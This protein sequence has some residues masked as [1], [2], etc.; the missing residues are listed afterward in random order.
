MGKLQV[1]R[2]L[3]SALPTLDSGELGF[4]TDTKRLFVGGIDG[5]NVEFTP[6]AETVDFNIH[7]A[8]SVFGGDT[9]A[10]GKTGRELAGG[11]TTST[12][13]NQLVDSAASFTSAMVGE[14]VHNDTDDTWAKVTSFVSATTLGISVDIMTSGEDY[15][16]VSALDNLTDGFNAVDSSFRAN[17]S[18]LMTPETFDGTTLTIVGKTAGAAKTLTFKGSTSGTTTISAEVDINQKIFFTNIVFT[19][20][21]FE[22]FG[23]DVDWTTCVTS[24][25][26]GFI[27][28]KSISI[29]N[30]F[31]SSSVVVF[32]SDP[33]LFTNIASTVTVGYTIYTATS[34]LGGSDTIN[35]GLLITQGTATSTSANKLVDSTANFNS[36]Q[37]LNKTVYN[38]TDNTWAEITAIDSTTQ[39]SLDQDIMVSGES[40]ELAAARST[41]QG[42]IDVIPGSV[43]C[44]TLQRISNGTFSEEVTYQGKGFSG[45]FN[46]TSRGTLNLE[47]TVSSATIAQNGSATQG[48]VTKA[49]AFTSDVYAGFLAYFV[50]DDDWRII[51]THT[52]DVLTLIANAPSNTT[53]DVK[54]YSW[55]TILNSGGAIDVNIKDG[56][57]GIF[58][59][60][61]EFTNRVAPSG[62]SKVDVVRSHLQ[63]RLQI[64][65]GS[66]GN[67]DRC[68]SDAPIAINSITGGSG[69]GGYSK[70]INSGGAFGV[71]ADPGSSYIL[72]FGTVIDGYVKGSNAISTSI[73]LD[74]GSIGY[75]RIRNCTTGLLGTSNGVHVAGNAA[76]SNLQ[77]SGNTTDASPAINSTDF[78]HTGA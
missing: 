49:A 7:L 14:T 57:L 77:F 23:A 19:S 36:A 24:G 60:D 18:I 31:R 52:N 15:H 32:K 10:N 56:Q 8:S 67:M 62:L 44:N 69:Q 61:L 9:E 50:T 4:A 68:W 46:I 75:M 78:S 33:G 34:A 28:T 12:S 58:L 1:R 72:A 25:D 59:D 43:N 35:D 11:T 16:V 73:R 48:T 76:L 71:R 40:Y 30:I 21:I 41:W 47:E 39:V 55:N 37:H 54:I 13:A 2:G 45:A 5:L 51:D 3:R 70:L 42:G 26:D 38:S 64:V 29:A 66:I 63:D 22:N 27:I 20:R 65:E 6:A 74:N 53:Q 17:I